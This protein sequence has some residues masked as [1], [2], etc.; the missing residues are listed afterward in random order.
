MPKSGSRRFCRTSSGHLPVGDEPAGSTR[1]AT[2]SG[3]GASLSQLGPDGR[4]AGP[5]KLLSAVALLIWTAGAAQSA[6]RDTTISERTMGYVFEVPRGCIVNRCVD[7]RGA[8]IPGCFDVDNKGGEP[9]VMVRTFGPGIFRALLG[10]GPLSDPGDTLLSYARAEAWQLCAGEGTPDSIVSLR[11]YRSMRGQEVFEALV[12]FTPGVDCCSEDDT[13]VV[14]ESQREDGGGQA[15]VAGPLF[16]VNLLRPGAAR[17]LV[18]VTPWG[19][20][21]GLPADAARVGRRIS[22]SVRWR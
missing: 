6:P 12:R 9:L 13:T 5:S 11:R 8:Q 20:Y 2:N 4:R 3:P 17:L 22:R 7:G 1:G 16:V 18:V 15:R 19:C 21:E 10:D 14:E